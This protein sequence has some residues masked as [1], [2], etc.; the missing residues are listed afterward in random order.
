MQKTIEHNIEK[1]KAI[2]LVKKAISG[3][4]AITKDGGDTLKVGAPMMNATI[5]ITDKTIDISGGGAAGAVASTCASEI[6][7]AVQE[8][9]EN[10]SGGSSNGGG[11][12]LSMEDQLK[13]AEAI[14][15]FKELADA[16]IITQEEFEAKKK[17]IL[18]SSASSAPKSAEVKAPVAEES[19]EV[20]TEASVEEKPAQA[21]PSE[22]QQLMKILRIIFALIPPI[23]LVFCLVFCSIERDKIDKAMF[24]DF[25]GL[26]EDW[27]LGHIVIFTAIAA[28][29][30]YSVLAIGKKSK[31]VLEIVFISIVIACSLY[32]TIMG[33]LIINNLAF[34]M[35]DINSHHEAMLSI[36]SPTVLVFAAIDLIFTLIRKR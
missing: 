34:Y 4:F 28:S 12:A 14:K 33:L 24:F 7:I 29:I 35:S 8:Y 17:E 23:L 26:E 13:A 10:Q 31:K 20:P 3:K 36:L 16:G 30:V 32:L 19:K 21:Q 11:A 27:P 18:S 2:R 9:Q 25:R 1:S 6:E 5:V 22:S 15:Q